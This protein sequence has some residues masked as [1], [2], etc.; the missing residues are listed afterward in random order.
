MRNIKLS[1]EHRSI[2]WDKYIYP[3]GIP[4]IWSL[5]NHIC[6][7]YMHSSNIGVFIGTNIYTQLEFH[8]YGVYW[9]TSASSICT[10][11][12]FNLIRP[13][14]YIVI[15]R[16]I[17]IS[18]FCCKCIVL[19]CSA[20]LQYN[21]SHHFLHSVFSFVLRCAALYCTVLGQIALCI[22][23]FSAL[24]LY[25]YHIHWVYLPNIGPCHVE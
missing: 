17:A 10:L 13:Q 14:C 18:I 2:H 12:N 11:S 3:A 16:P 6:F 15:M 23:Y 19:S 25:R 20:A 8:W 24:V 9:I 21:S 1:F 22:L 5:L 7:K 4:L